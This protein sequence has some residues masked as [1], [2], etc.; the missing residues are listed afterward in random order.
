MPEVI[1]E[2]EPVNE[3]KNLHQRILSIMKDIDYIQKGDKKVEQS[4]HFVSHDQVTALIHPKLVQ[5]G[6]VVV[7]S[8]KS[9]TQDGNRT[10]VCL[11]VTFVNVD[12][13]ADRISLEMWGYG[14]DQSDKGP[15]KAISYAFKYSILKMF[16]LETGDDP[17]QDATSKYEPQK[18]KEKSVFD[19][20]G[21]MYKVC[22]D[23]NKTFDTD[24]VDEYVTFLA[25]AKKSEPG[26]IMDYALLNAENT[27][28]FISSFETWKSKK[29]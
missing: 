8:V 27:T 6:I 10:N 23:M 13:P 25:M 14:V 12:N 4:V 21:A 22:G 28:R 2:G 9:L 18:E 15:G 1:I 5:H 26:K 16:C 3:S 29:S 24:L 19:L 17:D 7:P 20:L 11:E